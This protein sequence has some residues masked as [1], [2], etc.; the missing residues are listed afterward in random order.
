[1]KTKYSVGNRVSHQQFGE[2]MVV[3]VKN[4]QL[5][6]LFLDEQKRSFSAD[7]NE[8]TNLAVQDFDV[9]KSEMPL[10][11][12]SNKIKRELDQLKEGKRSEFFDYE[13]N[14]P[15]TSETVNN[16][17]RV[18][19][20]LFGE[21]MI[22][23]ILKNEY[24][25]I[26]L[27]GNKE[28]I[29]INSPELTLLTTSIADVF[30]NDKVTENIPLSESNSGLFV[31]KQVSIP[32]IGNGM[33]SRID[34]ETYEVIFMDGHKQSF[35]KDSNRKEV[36][37]LNIV[38]D[39]TDTVFVPQIESMKDTEEFKV[40]KQISQPGFGEGMI[41]KIDK[42]SYEII[43]LDGHKQKFPLSDKIIQQNTKV[44][45]EI[46]P[47]SKPDLKRKE[48]DFGINSIAIGK[49]YTDEVLGEGMISKVGADSYEVIFL[50]GHKQVYKSE[51]N[52]K[53]T[54]RKPIIDT[55][56]ELIENLKR[57]AKVEVAE[58]I[59]LPIERIQ[60]K[61]EFKA[62]AKKIF[63]EPEII[64]PKEKPS[65]FADKPIKDKILIDIEK[66]K[67]DEIMLGS[68]VSHPK[69]G[70]GMV[71]NMDDFEIEVVFYNHKKVVYSAKNNELLFI[72]VSK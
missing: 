26:F 6:I 50:N 8:I 11:S 17:T 4:N 59:E 10:P 69:H 21:G 52:D 33:I 49:Q 68:A 28:N 41:S 7:S 43:F 24:Q 29:P 62:P 3:Q 1:M 53:L 35:L 40:G 47:V 22:T 13:L 23:K 57:K 44:Q 38:S 60:P 2:G 30:P 61:P 20:S 58:E 25:I 31:G 64:I 14:S 15:K 19:H 51:I 39:K 18:F 46:R 5:D 36:E 66:F 71:S 54:E 42:D 16:N 27:N 34:D 72:N 56:P 9:A 55:T 67:S 48:S 45:D 65:V 12:A 37:S 32:N 63:S 70:S